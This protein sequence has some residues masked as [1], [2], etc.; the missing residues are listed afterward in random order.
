MS[1]SLRIRAVRPKRISPE[2]VR[3]EPSGLSE[4]E[5]VFA[6][7]EAMPHNSGH[8]V[9]AAEKWLPSAPMIAKVR[10]LGGAR[11]ETR[12]APCRD[13]R[14]D[15][16][17]VDSS[18]IAATAKMTHSKA[19]RVEAPNR[20]EVVKSMKLE[21]IDASPTQT[22][23]TPL[24]KAAMSQ[25]FTVRCAVQVRKQSRSG[26]GKNSAR[27]AWWRTSRHSSF[28]GPRVHKMRAASSSGS[29]GRLSSTLAALRSSRSLTT[30][31]RAA[32]RH[33]VDWRT[34]RESPPPPDRPSPPESISG[35][36]ASAAP[37]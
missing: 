29:R 18:P 22:N 16:R 9:A 34:R 14:C 19:S 31:K 35:V 3:R 36:R 21:A 37:A 15:A 10:T 20:A 2:T 27:R 26:S 1:S 12:P 4:T 8:K 25:G 5:A 7:P 17:A 11:T 23:K 24:D 28:A 32:P 13:W 6:F 30:P 33:R